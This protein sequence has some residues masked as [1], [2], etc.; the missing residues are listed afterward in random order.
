MSQDFNADAMEGTASQVFGPT[1]GQPGSTD[2]L[3]H[4]ELFAIVNTKSD[5]NSL[6]LASNSSSNSHF[7]FAD[8]AFTSDLNEIRRSLLNHRPPASDKALLK[9]D[10]YQ[11][12]FDLDTWP[13]MADP[14]SESPLTL[15]PEAV[16]PPSSSG[17]SSTL[18]PAKR[19]DSTTTILTLTNIDSNTRGEI[20]EFLCKRKVITRIEIE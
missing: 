9:Q 11:P 18:M 6:V 20:L 13:S 10:G 19:G 14:A 8:P 16:T 15:P 2:R 5:D 4:D 3:G 7:S 12:A 17:G 1:L